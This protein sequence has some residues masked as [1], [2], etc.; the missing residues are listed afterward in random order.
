MRSAEPMAMQRLGGR[1]LI[2]HILASVTE[3]DLTRLVVV[4]GPRMTMVAEAVRPLA[5]VVQGEPRGTGH[6]GKT[7]RDALL[8]FTGVI[9]HVPSLSMPA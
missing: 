7:V 1:P 2:V 4:L 3:L 5:T 6:A 9:V 8:G